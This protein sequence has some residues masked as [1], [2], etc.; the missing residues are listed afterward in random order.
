MGKQLMIAFIV[1]NPLKYQNVKKK[2][3][4]NFPKLIWTASDW[5]L[6]TMQKYRVEKQKQVDVRTSS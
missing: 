3:H 5:R 6:T 4:N 1:S 2:A